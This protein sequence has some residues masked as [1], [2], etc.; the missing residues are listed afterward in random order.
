[1]QAWIGGEGG[2]CQAL[3]RASVEDLLVCS[4]REVRGVGCN[5]RL[6]SPAWWAAAV[7]S[8]PPPWCDHTG[9][10]LLGGWCVCFPF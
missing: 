5:R 1:M 6:G 4:G 10:V 9:D 3:L 2:L 8:L 7:G